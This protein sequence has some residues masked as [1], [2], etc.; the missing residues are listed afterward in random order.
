MNTINKL[1]LLI[2]LLNLTNTKEVSGQY[3]NEVGFG[4]GL[5]GYTGEASRSPFTRPSYTV[6]ALYR[7]NF[8]SRF[9]ISAGLDYGEI[10]V[11]SNKTKTNFP[12]VLN[13][14]KLDVKTQCFIPE[15]LLDINFF[16]FPKMGSVLNSKN[17]TPYY[18]V[19]I[20]MVSYMSNDPVNNE[21]KYTMGIP[22]GVGLRHIFSEHWG[23]QV[24]FKATKTFADD[25]DHSKLSNPYKL[26]NNGNALHLND[27]L[28]ATTVMLTYS[29]GEDHWECNCTK[30]PKNKRNKR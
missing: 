1:A 4:G 12:P 22:F 23:V 17:T 28:Y 21:L 13:G 2:I 11:N 30:T 7:Y 10:L 16:P 6:G 29:F 24:R 27:W 14:N 15:V 9:S 18:F 25:I 5:S 19:G 3:L 26:N 8:N 20:N